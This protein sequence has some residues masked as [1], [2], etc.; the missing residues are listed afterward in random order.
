MLVRDPNYAFHNPVGAFAERQNIKMKKIFDAP[1]INVKS[2]NRENILT[3]SGDMPKT[4]S[5]KAAEAL[6]NGGE[7]VVS[8]IRLTI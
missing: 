6:N 1:T 8:I 7:S 3:A 5:E 2:F 4:A